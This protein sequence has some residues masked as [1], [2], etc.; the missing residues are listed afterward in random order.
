MWGFFKHIINAYLNDQDFIEPAQASSVFIYFMVRA[1]NEFK[2]ANDGNGTPLNLL[3]QYIHKVLEVGKVM[4]SE[5]V[6]M[7]GIALI[8]AIMEHLGPNDPL[9]INYIDSINTMY[10][11]EMQ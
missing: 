1:P 3:F 9:I 2:N 8:I 5:M 4:E 7:S 11:T 6:S 10:L